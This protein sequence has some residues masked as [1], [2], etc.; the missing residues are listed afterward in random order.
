MAHFQVSVTYF[1]GSD[2]EYHLYENGGLH[3]AT[4]RIEEMW[5]IY[6]GEIDEL[7]VA[8]NSVKDSMDLL[9]EPVEPK[10]EEISVDISYGSLLKSAFKRGILGAFVAIFLGGMYIAIKFIINDYALSEDELKRRTGVDI[11]ATTKRF[12]GTG[13]WQ[14]FLAKLSGDDRRLDGM[15]AVASLAAVNIESILRADNSSERSVLLVGHNVDKINEISRLMANVD[16]IV[17][18]DILID[19]DAV[20]KLNEYSNV[21]IVEEK[22]AVS[23]TEIARECEKLNKLHKSILGIIAL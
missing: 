23:Y 8:K 2:S 16:A 11:L 14:K 3:G 7:V 22:E 20:S 13:K 19:K 15:E 4:S 5:R 1:N 9:T 18:G 12:T 10:G 6:R 17:G 21:V